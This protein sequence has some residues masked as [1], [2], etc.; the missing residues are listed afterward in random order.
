LLNIDEQVRLLLEQRK[1]LDGALKNTVKR[2]SEVGEE[3]ASLD[4]E[5]AKVPQNVALFNDADTDPEGGARERL[6]TLKLEEEKYTE[7]SPAAAEVRKQ[8][9]EVSR[10]LAEQEKAPLG[11]VRK[12]KNPVFEELETRKHLLTT[13]LEPL[14]VQ[15]AIG[16]RQLA[17]IDAELA[18]LNGHQSMLRQL[19]RQVDVDEQTYRTYL[20]KEDEARVT[21]ALDREKLTNISTVQQPTVPTRG[22]GLSRTMQVL[23][24][25]VLGFLAAAGLCVMAEFRRGVFMNPE[26]IERR[27]G[28]RVLLTVPHNRRLARFAH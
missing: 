27:L 7:D 17:E 6:L 23:L 25:G 14:R 18:E 19:R 9:E 21:E 4:K 8:I 3:L 2:L 20:E 28:V 24:A 10:F 16:E 15:R 22:L 5:M 12:G 11:S 1:D 13:E 26:D